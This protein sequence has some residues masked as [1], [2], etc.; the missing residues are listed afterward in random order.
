MRWVNKAWM[1]VRSIVRRDHANRELDEELRFHLE[2]QIA[3]NVAAGM[4]REEARDAAMREFG[5]VDQIREECSDVR[6]VNWLQDLIQDVRYGLRMLR[7]SPGFTAVA[8]VTL[9]L[10]I[11]ANTAIF[12]VINSVLLRNLPVKDPQQLVFLTN[13]DERGMEIG[14]GDGDRDFLTYP[15]YQQLAK[16]NG[17]FSGLAAVG[18]VQAEVGTDVEGSGQNGGTALAKVSLVSGSYFSVLGVNPTLGRTFDAEVD[19]VRDANPVA[20]ISYAFWQGRLGADPGAL[21]RQ[22]RIHNTSFAVIGIMPPQFRGDTVGIYPD[23]WAPLTMQGEIL[24]GR[25]YLSQETKPFHK[26]EW[27]QAMGRL[28]EGVSIEQAK[29]N[30][31]AI[32]QQMLQSQ[33]GQMSAKESRTFLNQ[34][35]AVTEGRHGASI[36]RQPFGKP[37]KILMAAV[38]VILLIACANL[39]NILLARSASRQKEIGVRI[40]MGAGSSRLVRQVL[41]E[42]IL[43]AAIGGVLGLVLARWA[44]AGLLRMV[45][46]GPSVLPVDIHPD[47]KMLG[48]TLGVSSLTGILFG[49]APAFRAAHVDL[50]SVFKGTSRGIAGGSQAGRLPTGKVLVVAQVALSL[51]LLVVA[52]LFL[53]SFRNLA[54]VQLG[55]D[56]DHLLSFGVSPVSY[57]YKDGEIPA[58]YE[59]MLQRIEA[60][61]GVR[62]AS[63]MDNGVFGG[64]D[65]SSAITVEGAKPTTDQEHDERWDLVGP[66]FF[67]T[68]GIR[69]RLGREIGAQDGGNG[70]RVGVINESLARH[71]FADSNPIG[72]R[73]RVHT[74]LTAADFVVVGVA[75]DSKQNSIREK[76]QPRFYIP[77]FQSYW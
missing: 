4:S 62:R 56:R 40:A 50:N 77:F 33:T 34:H 59:Q 47:A 27:I 67:S 19:Q 17:V 3:E 30:V 52:G 43:L 58:L 6:N 31:N 70:Q 26:T 2:R 63:L 5:G 15:E 35:L 61:P 46:S 32:F 12:S 68:V 44:D 9:A 45:S 25:D 53:R 24:P 13:P 49:V 22:I 16:T 75:A 23:L 41:T 69:I 66:N 73:I 54:E 37:L 71:Y 74:T 14:F 76:L 36:L 39:A 51:L 8:I 60:V 11:G 65:S 38:G 29:A 28:K 20:V 55:F 10:G 57:G 21:G 42:S 64:T 1:W 7:K 18:S 48:F 72:K